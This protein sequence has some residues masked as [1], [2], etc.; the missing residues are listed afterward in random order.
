MTDQSSLQKVLSGFKAKGVKPV[1]DPDSIPTNGHLRTVEVDGETGFIHYTGEWSRQI[2]M[3]VMMDADA[4]FITN[5]TTVDEV[6]TA[7]TPA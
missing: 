5:P 7:L 3:R 1:I 2:A 4:N 6:R